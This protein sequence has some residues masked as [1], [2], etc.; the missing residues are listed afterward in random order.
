MTNCS[1]VQVY[2]QPLTNC[3]FVHILQQL[4]TNLLTNWSIIQVSQQP[5]TNFIDNLF[6]C[7]HF[8]TIIELNWQIG[9]FTNFFNNYWI[10][11]I[12]QV[13]NNCWPI[14]QLLPNFIDK[15]ANCPHFYQ[16]L[17]DFTDTLVNFLKS[18][19]LLT[20]LNWLRVYCFFRTWKLENETGQFKCASV[21]MIFYWPRNQTPIRLNSGQLLHQLLRRKWQ[22]IG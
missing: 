18:Q 19:Q 3:L 10:T 8:S 21:W 9:Q 20:N 1:I 17:T 6:N 12:V 22:P 15:L 2:Q 16:L 4:L 11:L 13:F 7:P 14:E 5:M